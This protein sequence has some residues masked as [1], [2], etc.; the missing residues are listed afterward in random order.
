M[1]EEDNDDNKEE[2]EMEDNDDNNEEEEM[3]HN[4][5]NKK[6]EEENFQICLRKFS[7]LSGKIFRFVQ[8]NF[9][10]IWEN[11]QFCAI[12]SQTPDRQSI[13]P[14]KIAAES[15]LPAAAFP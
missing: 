13:K 14:P 3:E 1:E 7:D 15:A 9:Q 2:K 8:K 11:W 12:L 6:E 4:D 10:I 5:D